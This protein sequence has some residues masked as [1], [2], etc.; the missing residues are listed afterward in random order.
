MASGSFLCEAVV[1]RDGRFT[2]SVLDFGFGIWD[3]GLRIADLDM[4]ESS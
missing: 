2:G 3:W 4:P 1:V